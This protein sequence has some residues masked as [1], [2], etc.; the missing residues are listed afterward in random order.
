MRRLL[1]LLLA[2]AAV[3]APACPAEERPEGIVERW[4][5]SLNQGAA[6]HPDR[7]ASAQ[8]SRLV[9]PGHDE[10]DPET[11]DRIEVGQGESRAL[12]LFVERYAVPF[13]VERPDGRR[14]RGTAILRANRDERRVEAVS[15]GTFDLRLPSEGGPSSEGVTTLA[16][17]GALG[18]AALLIALTAAL[19]RL[20]PERAASLRTR[21]AS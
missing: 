5:L 13:L 10:A 20:V 17:F 4:L 3:A 16:W 15:L 9:L 19:M 11:F 2:L 12:N 21:R 8:V 18:A 14:L 7:Y 6:G 1:L